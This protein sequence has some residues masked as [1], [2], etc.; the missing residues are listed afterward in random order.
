MVK[1]W[2]RFLGKEFGGLHEA[3]LLLA[4]ATLLSQVLA[5]VRDRLLAGT[6]GAGSSL[7]IYYSAFRL[8]DLIYATIASFIS[9]TVIIPFLIERLEAGEEGL[10]KGFLSAVFTVFSCV[11]ISVSMIAFWLLPYLAPYLAPGFTSLALEQLVS[12]SRI[13]LLSPLLLGLSNLLGSITQTYRKFLIFSLSPVVYNVGI[14]L[15]IIFLVPIWGLKGLAWGV[16]LGALGHLLIQIPVIYK[17]GLWPR[18]SLLAVKSNKKVLV[19]LIWISWPRTLTLSS[20]QLVMLILLALASYMNKGSVA[21]FN[22]SFNLQSVPLAIIG[23]S[24][25]VAAFPILSRYFAKGQIDHFLK[26]IEIA[27]RHIAF[28]S[29]PTIFMFVVLRAQIVRVI[30]GFGNFDWTATRLTAACLAL[31]AISVSA[32]SLVA[33]LVRAY[34]ASGRTFKPLLISAA[35]SGLIIVLAFGLGVLFRESEAWRLFWEN[36]LRVRG[37]PGSAVLMLPLAYTIGLLFNLIILT[38]AFVIDYRY[39][40]RVIANSI[41]RS[42]VGA[43]WGGITAYLLLNYL[44][45]HLD[46]NTVF[47]IF[48]Q[49]FIAGLGGLLINFIVL[50][51]LGSQELKEIFMAIRHKFWQKEAIVPEQAEL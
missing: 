15:G 3:A 7:D 21:I 19:K 32:Q 8:P 29:L 20:S 12:L 36:I 13:L 48:T 34:Y 2:L 40:W 18:F 5:L 26:Q 44:G 9:V 28:W 4:T 49:G 39:R 42:L 6:F 23:V 22:F 43:V 45:P 33:L 47:G 14:I 10:A 30:L 41:G 46:L 24:Y 17:V 50:L 11:L 27:S 31:F 16:A 35:S 51:I 25:S 37:L 38:I 1:S